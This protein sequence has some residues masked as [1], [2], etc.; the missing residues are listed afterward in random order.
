M[1]RKS[2]DIICRTAFNS[3]FGLF[4]NVRRVKLCVVVFYGDNE[5]YITEQIF[6]CKSSNLKPS[7]K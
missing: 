2:L 5:R 6:N 3:V 1:I 7:K 4:P